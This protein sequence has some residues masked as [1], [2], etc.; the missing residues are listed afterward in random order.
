M[1]SFWSC[2]NVYVPG[3]VLRSN[4]NPARKPYDNNTT[5]FTPTFRWTYAQSYGY[6]APY[7]CQLETEYI[8]RRTKI[9]RKSKS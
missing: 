7:H 3:T 5:N 2:L 4:S 1:A 6:T 9:N 8:A